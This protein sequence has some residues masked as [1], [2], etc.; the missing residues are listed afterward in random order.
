MNQPPQGQRFSHVYIKRGEPAPDS[1]RMR[2]RIGAQIHD[3][4]YLTESLAW[5]IQRE[6]GVFVPGLPQ[7]PI[8]LKEKMGL[9]DVVDLVTI[10]YRLLRAQRSHYNYP[11]QWLQNIQRIFEE[12]NVSYRVDS[13][14]GVHFHIDEE[15]A[16]NQA[17]AI[18]ALQPSRYANALHA[19]E[20]AMDELSKVPP[21]G[22]GAI[23]GVFAAAESI[24]KLIL[25]RVPRLG[26]AEL[27]DLTPLL[28]RA[29]PN[30]G[31]ARHSSSRMLGSLKDWVD[32]AHFYRHE[33]GKPDGVAQPPLG[34]AVYIVSTGASHVRW[35]AELDA[36]LQ[37]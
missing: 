4:K 10:A 3:F 11:E 25:P 37:K 34:L 28:Q 21:N 32:A 27:D 24:F 19:F 13:M 6:I 7:W 33:Q 26:A 8:V 1:E 31:T 9:R 36:L 12:E 16:R 35:L 23:R 15:Y 18:A 22:K 29:H 5:Q 2:H 30:E 17:S 20:G 14:G